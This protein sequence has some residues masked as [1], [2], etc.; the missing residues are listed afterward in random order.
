MQVSD[1]YKAD[2]VS[3]QS[4]QERNKDTALTAVCFCP[5]WVTDYLSAWVG[6]KSI[7]TVTMQ[8][9]SQLLH[10]LA[11]L[12]SWK[13]RMRILLVYVRTGHPKEWWLI[14]QRKV[15]ISSTCCKPYGHFRG[16]LDFLRFKT[17]N[18]SQGGLI[19]HSRH[20]QR[21]SISKEKAFL[22]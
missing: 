2:L 7:C 17:V 6:G 4:N 22:C 14:S 19:T 15:I 12:H 10:S 21:M 8:K 3:F 9:H 1:W 18:I 13:K 5:Q 20:K 11:S 16:H